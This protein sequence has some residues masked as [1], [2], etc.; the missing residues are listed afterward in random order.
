[1]SIQTGFA[2]VNGAQ[3]YYEIAGEGQPMILLHAGVA[4]CRMWDEQFAAFAEHYRV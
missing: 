4:N 1:M 2:P 3:L